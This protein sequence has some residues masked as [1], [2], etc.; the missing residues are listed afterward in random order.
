[1]I[2]ILE[3]ADCSGKSTL[4]EQIH[5]QTGYKQLHRTQPKTEEDKKC[6]MDE[7]LQ[8][9]KANKNCILD[10]SWYSEMVY[11]PVMRDASVISYPQMYEL[12]RMLTKNG[13][14]LIYCTAPE[15]T[16]WKRCLR[17]GEEYI[18]KPDD[19]HNICKGFDELMYDVPHFIP[20]LTYEYK[21]M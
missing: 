13:A 15:P 4:A 9:I 16:L 7:Y 5:K 8:V 10:R 2:L 14:L 11:G 6:M 3:G 20:V 21:D 1:M 17:R 19:F 12:E 18:T